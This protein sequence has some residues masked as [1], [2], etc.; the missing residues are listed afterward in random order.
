MPDDPQTPTPLKDALDK[1]ASTSPSQEAE[2][3]L[4]A[5]RDGGIGVA[6]RVSTTLGKGWS[7]D[8]K[9]QYVHRTG[10]TVAAVARWKGK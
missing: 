6:G 1:L 4:V 3:G 5:E 8:A 9:G 10:W 7:L 2:I